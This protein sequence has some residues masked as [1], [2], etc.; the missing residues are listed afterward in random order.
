[1][2]NKYI[3]KV[4]GEMQ[5]FFDEQGFVAF[6]NGYKNGTKAVKI[7][8]SDERQM[9]LLFCADVAED[10]TVGDFAETCSWL[11]DDTQNAKDAESVGIDF[12]NT[13]RDTMGIKVKKSVSKEGIDLPVAAKGDSM[14][15]SGFAKKVLD[16]FPQYKETYKAHIAKYGNFLYMD[17]FADTLVPQIACTLSENNKKSTKKLFELMENAYI[18]GDR[19]TVNIVVASLAAAAV[20]SSDTKT[21]VLAMLENNTHFKSA[22][23]ALIP[24][25]ASNAKLNKAIVKG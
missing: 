17:F 22:V 1:M 15:V 21:A 16:V 12:V 11:F 13:L 10:G 7:E 9:Y 4:I 25:V 8:Y 20:K 5:P 23:E 14:D 3:D 2:D 19:D 24:I 18:H 6:E